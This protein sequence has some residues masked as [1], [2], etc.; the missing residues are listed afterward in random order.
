MS[1]L[2][3]LDN[4]FGA[5]LETIDS[6]R[7]I[8]YVTTDEI[9]PVHVAQQEKIDVYI[10][11]DENMPVNI[12]NPVERMIVSVNMEELFPVKIAPD[13]KIVTY[14]TQDEKFIL[15]VNEKIPTS[16]RRICNPKEINL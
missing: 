4:E 13:E 3:L 2:L 14:I 15:N 10:I 9:I 6:V 12:G 11:M 1:L 16:Q 7:F 8:V 5:A